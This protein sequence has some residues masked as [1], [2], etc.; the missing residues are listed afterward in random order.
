MYGAKAERAF[1]GQWR[2]H[3]GF[4]VDD[5][6]A[7]KR[8]D[9]AGRRMALSHLAGHRRSFSAFLAQANPNLR[10]PDVAALLQ[11]HVNQLT[12]ALRTSAGGRYG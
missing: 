6:V 3:I 7:L 12:G 5:T 8:H 4:L 10:A 9:A 2:S 1:L 11:Q